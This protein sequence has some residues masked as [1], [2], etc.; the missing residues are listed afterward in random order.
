ML[1]VTSREELIY[2]ETEY[3]DKSAELR[4][5]K[6]EERKYEIQCLLDFWKEIKTLPETVAVWKDYLKQS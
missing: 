3:F 5:A 1:W 6:C 4:R 2:I